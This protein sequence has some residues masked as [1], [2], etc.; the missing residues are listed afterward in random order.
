MHHLRRALA[1]SALAAA[2][3]AQSKPRSEA[4]NGEPQQHDNS[5]FSLKKPVAAFAAELRQAPA[6]Q[7]AP[8]LN[9]HELRFTK[10]ASI[11]S[12]ESAEYRTPNSTLM[13]P[14]DFLDS[15]T[16][17]QPDAVKITLQDYE[18]NYQKK[19]FTRRLSVIDKYFKKNKDYV[20]IF[21]RLGNYGLLTY[22]DYLFLQSLLSK[23]ERTY[24]LAFKLLDQDG[25]C[26][27][28]I[29]EYT[30]LEKFI[31]GG[32]GASSESAKNLTSN[33]QVGDTKSVPS[34]IKYLFFG[35]ESKSTLDLLRFQ[36]FSSSVQVEILA[37]EF[38]FLKRGQIYD[39]TEQ[40]EESSSTTSASASVP[41]SRLGHR[42]HAVPSEKDFSY[43]PSQQKI[44]ARNFAKYIL[45]QTRL[46]PDDIEERLEHIS[47]K[48][49][50]TEISFAE[51]LDFSQFLGNISD[52]GEVLRFIERNKDEDEQIGP[53]QLSEAI[54]IAIEITLTDEVINILY[55]L[56][57]V[58]EDGSISY[59]EMITVFRSRLDRASRSHL[60][61]KKMRFKKCVLNHGYQQRL[62][63]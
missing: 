54:Q 46:L 49:P 53:K 9:K 15:I 38:E 39:D 63:M 55:D 58:N 61:A 34:L 11:I 3:V 21:G 17:G 25:N 1:S 42:N 45:R 41:E 57:D 32:E 23:N 10:F 52:F 24:H 59:S 6:K 47:N 30:D 40:D 35:E 20:Q 50:E 37:R 12:D 60:D 2:A 26:E 7:I 56:F 8:T 44:S 5:N 27:L 51:F 33:I 48:Y 36:R 28:D 22:S 19:E 14:L 62:A 31:C 29:E 4:Q 16:L 13:T 43:N 18:E